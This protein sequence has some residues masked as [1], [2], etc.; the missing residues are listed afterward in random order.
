[1][2]QYIA[3]EIQNGTYAPPADIVHAVE[4]HLKDYMDYPN[5]P[6][7]RRWRG[8]FLQGGRWKHSTSSPCS[9]MAFGIILVGSS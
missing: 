8:E 6:V 7:L 5:A 4:E 1:M 2:A 9:S 3:G